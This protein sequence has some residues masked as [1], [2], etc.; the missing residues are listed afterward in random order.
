[1]ATKINKIEIHIK[2]RI[3]ELK[4]QKDELMQEP[5]YLSDVKFYDLV[6]RILELEELL[7]R[8]DFY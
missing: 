4:K 3:G 5:D 7:M 1:M 2:G 6:G 8:M